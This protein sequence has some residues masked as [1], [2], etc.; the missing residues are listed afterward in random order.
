MNYDSESHNLLFKK[1]NEYVCNL[2]FKSNINYI[3][4]EIM[5]VSNDFSFLI[6]LFCDVCMDYL[7]CFVTF[8]INQF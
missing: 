1:K 4:I 2:Q 8:T 3:I 7:S 6:F 5:S